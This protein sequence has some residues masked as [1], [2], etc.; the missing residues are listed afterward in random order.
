MTD[1]YCFCHPIQK[2]DLDSGDS[3]CGL[4]IA[5]DIWVSGGVATSFFESTFR[6]SSWLDIFAV[7]VV[8]QLLLVC[9]HSYLSAESWCSWGIG[10][11]RC[12]R[13]GV[14]CFWMAVTMPICNFGRCFIIKHACLVQLSP[15]A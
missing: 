13:R 12:L 1:L 15:F 11:V 6:M 8:V 10:L 7:L 9:L 4:L 5:E 2:P 3:K 14:G